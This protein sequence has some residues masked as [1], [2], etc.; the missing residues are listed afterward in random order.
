MNCAQHCSSF[1][2]GSNLCFLA[3]GPSDAVSFEE[4][5]KF[6]DETTKVIGC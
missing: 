2:S 5:V 6:G 1:V 3:F 4:K